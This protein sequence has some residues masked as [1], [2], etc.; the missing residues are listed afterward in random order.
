MKS[1]FIVLIA[2][3]IASSIF[4]LWRV[5]A[6]GH[7]PITYREAVYDPS[8]SFA[9]GCKA[10]VGVANDLLLEPSASSRASLSVS[11][12]GDAS[13][14]DEPRPIVEYPIPESR[15]IIGGR[16]AGDDLRGK[17]LED[18]WTKCA[19]L[20][21]TSV[22]PIHLGVQQAIADLHAKGCKV[23]TRC[24]L[25]VATDLEENA[26]Q[27]IERNQWLAALRITS[28]STRQCRNCGYLLWICSNVGPGQPFVPPRIREAY[29]SRAAAG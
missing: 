24:E 4:I 14:A 10:L 6:M 21:S 26:D 29:D 5:N 16:H 27:E 9:G 8:L 18:L 3:S 15:E 19:A 17:T 22:S 7:D 20:H 11:V 2:G 12:M 13:T 25:W 1:H 23:G 28:C